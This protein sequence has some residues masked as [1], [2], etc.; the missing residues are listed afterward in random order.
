MIAGGGI[1]G[2]AA[3]LALSRRGH[4][5]TVLES[6][7]EFT[8]LG[9]GIQVAPNGFHA[10]DRLGVGTSVRERAVYVDDLR[11]MDGLSGEAVAVLPLGDAYRRRFGNPYAVMHRYDLYEPLLTACRDADGVELVAG[12]RVAGYTQSGRTV[13]AVLSDGREVRGDALVGADGINSA[14]RG[15]LLGDGPPRVSG[16]TIHRSVIPM[17]VVPADLRRNGATV[18]AG[19]GWHVVHYPIARGT[20][21]NLAATLDD[22]AT[23]AVA[24]R[25]AAREQVVAAFPGIAEAPRRLLELARD[26]RTWVLCDRDPT[27]RWADGRVVL[28]GDAAHPMLQYAAQGACQAL[29]DAVVLADLVG[30]GDDPARAFEHFAGLRRTRTSAAQLVARTI[31]ERLYHPSGEAARE[32]NALLAGLTPADLHDKVAWLH[33]ERC[34]AGPGRTPMSLRPSMLQES[35]AHR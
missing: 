4:R 5:V 11:L 32:R 3:A 8:E 17:D 27:D 31:G 15:R 20:L 35:H 18:W 34:G 16:H 25:P 28:L 33:G 2:L 7:P 14:V 26:W 30:S 22:R 10:L 12:C 1:G 13:T 19:P 23:E 21:L 29:E 6:R 24:G 9:A